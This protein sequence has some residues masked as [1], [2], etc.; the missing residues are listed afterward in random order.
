[1]HVH[2]QDMPNLGAAGATIKVN[3]GYARNYLLP[4][5][6]AAV[7]RG[8]QS[9][10]VEGVVEGGAARAAAKAKG[11]HVSEDESRRQAAASQKKKLEAIVRKLTTAPLV[12][13]HF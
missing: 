5:K 4:R 11:Q 3:H 12:S 7:R 9:G 8:K 6:L 13:T 10:S 2:D 1:M